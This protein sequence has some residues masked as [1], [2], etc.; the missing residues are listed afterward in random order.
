MKSK[1]HFNFSQRKGLYFRIILTNSCNNSCLYCFKEADV[2]RNTGKFTVSFF[3]ELVRV[4]EKYRIPKVHFTGGEPLLENRLVGFIKRIRRQSDIDV[5]LTTNG[6]LLRFYSK[7]LYKVGLKR[8]NVSIPT[9]DS[10]KY[11][12]ICRQNV[13]GEVLQNVEGLIS[14]NYNPIKINIPIF[15]QNVSEIG[16]FLTYFLTK[17]NIILRFFSVL[18]NPG[19]RSKDCLTNDE[20]INTLEKKVLSLPKEIQ[21]KS[22]ERV[23]YR[24]PN[25]APLGMCRNCPHKIICQ[26]E[27]KAIRITKDGKFSLC[28]L[29]SRY[30]FQINNV[31]E[32]ETATKNLLSHYN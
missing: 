13:L 22:M 32:I 8:I 23:F 16:D 3:D 2:G 9:L 27:A 24:A 25:Q 12:L 4:A 20:T 29:N 15:K 1:Y 30:S 5:G 6:T 10:H 11:R 31:D 28:L 14:L 19:L 18:P 7:E 17:D 26:D 21:E